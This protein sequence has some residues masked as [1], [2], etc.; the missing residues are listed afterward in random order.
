MTEAV[1]TTQHLAQM[2]DDIASRILVLVEQV[3]PATSPD[4]RIGDEALLAALA[5][6]LGPYGY[7]TLLAS[8]SASRSR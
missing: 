4:A 5:R 1:Q 8:I 7:A 3:A 2:V 6:R